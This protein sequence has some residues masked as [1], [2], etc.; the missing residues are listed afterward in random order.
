LAEL[1][2]YAALPYVHLDG[3][4]HICL[5]TSRETKRW[6][7]PKG[8]PKPSVRPHEQAAREAREE[9][10]LV[11]EI[12]PDPL[13]SYVYNKRMD[14]RKYVTCR[15]AVFPFLVQA[16]RIRWPEKRERQLLW[17]PIEDAASK[18]AEPDLALLLSALPVWVDAQQDMCL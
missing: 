3:V 13:G 4:L 18:V 9:A 15:V 17:T 10:G 6:V 12:A 7:I 16:Q 1:A 5:I 14:R 11:G 2:Q 8:W